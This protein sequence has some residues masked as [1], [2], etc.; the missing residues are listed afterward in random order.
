MCFP[1]LSP[2]LRCSSSIPG[3]VGGSRLLTEPRI[4]YF[5][6]PKTGRSLMFPF[7]PQEQLVGND[8][9]IRRSKCLIFLPQQEEPLQI[10]G[11]L[12]KFLWLLLPL[13][14]VQIFLCKILLPLPILILSVLPNKPP[15][16]GW[17]DIRGWIE[18]QI[19]IRGSESDSQETQPMTNGYVLG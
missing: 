11:F 17:I 2:R 18:R 19:D 5:P 6:Q 3:H 1:D 14:I 13:H 7:L 4:R 10:Q 9:S 15:V 16:D 12:Y 8:W